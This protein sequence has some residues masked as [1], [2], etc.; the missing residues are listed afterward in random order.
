VGLEDVLEARRLVVVP[1]THWDREWYRT[2]EEFRYRLVRL[3]DDVLDLLER[4]DEF[5][6]FT[7]DGQ[8]VVLADY[9]EVRPRVRERLT[10]L[11]R[12]GRLIVGPWF[13]LPDEW[14]VSGEA[15]IRN[16]RLGMRQAEAFG[17]AMRLGYVPDQFGH[18]GQ[19]PQLFAGFG[20]PAAVLWRGV[21]EDVDRTLFHWEAP[22]GTRL[23][24]VYLPFGYGNAVHLPRDPDSL[25]ARLR[26]EVG[27]LEAMSDVPT[28][29]LMNGSDH[30]RPR[31]DLPR[32]LEH[33]VR[34]IGKPE[35][36][37][38]T[39]PGFVER[40]Q[41][42]APADLPLHRGELRSG[43]RSP[44][45]PGCASARLWIKQ[46]DFRNDRLLTRYLEPLA[47]WVG[48]LGVD[49]DPEVIDHA[50]RSALENHPHDSICGCSVDR[51]H[52][53]M[54]ERFRRTEEI[55]ASHLDLVTA[56]W[57]SR[58]AACVDGEEGETLVVWSPHPAGPAE[59]V[60]DVELDLPVGPKG[61]KAFHLQTPDGRSVAASAE[62]L[63][64]EQVLSELSL[65]PAIVDWMLPALEGEFGGLHAQAV[66]WRRRGEK[67][68]FEVRVGSAPGTLDLVTLRRD[69]AAALEDDGVRRVAFRARRPAR[70]RLR[71]VDE[72]PGWG[73]R[74]YRVVPGAASLPATLE[75]RELSGGGV[76]IAN[77]SW[78]VEVQPDGR[79]MLE[80]RS[81][82]ERIDD[83]LRV[84][85]EGDRGDEYNFDPVPDETPVARPERVRL[86]LDEPSAT[87]VGLLIDA[88]YRVPAG[89]ARHRRARSRRRVTLP[90]RVHLR[91]PRSLDRVDVDI[92]VDNTVQDHRLRVELRAPFKATRFQV[93]SAFEVVERPIAPA[94]SA[95]GSDHPAERPIGACPQRSFACL[96]DGRRTWTVANRGLAEVEALEEGRST[97]LAI[98]LLR[99]VGW[100]SRGDLALRP[101]DAGPP[102]PTPGAQVPGPHRAELSL[103]LDEMGAAAPSAHA[104]RFAYPPLAV[105]GGGGS[106]APVRDGDSLV[107][108]SAPLVL[109]TAIEPRAGGAAVLRGYN[110]SSEPR[111]V[112]VRWLADPGRRLEPIDLAETHSR[113]PLADEEVELELRPWELFTLRVREKSPR[114]EQE[115]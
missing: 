33:A 56:E 61:V 10:K 26:F 4:D 79:V 88:R 7:L 89:L 28:V 84:V 9:L 39:L 93:E 81:G 41:A 49:A 6:H 98:T 47:A 110:A 85:S 54:R 77:E 58:V 23:F 67:L 68:E 75:A 17:G 8:T 76:A 18:V 113:G 78:R 15:L 62:L 105:V 3:L 25:V 100:L 83:A 87:H 13:V 94:P 48:A 34:E 14:L 114:G 69:L 43:L 70:L 103:R 111:R 30:V 38:G 107:A 102:L 2:H 65:P 11:I 42:E 80:S 44:L 36:E 60:A 52:D 1:H 64:P 72:M 63:E 37:I 31:A 95:F 104:H 29:L 73:L 82:G 35:L 21:G 51:V 55:A 112:R 99:A 115:R 74:A 91:L 53:Q 96:D 50:W 24:S 59:A 92:E 109:L 22:D 19:L 5:R 106:A 57:T 32:A 46:A 40:A 27:R 66:R 45:L 12:A 71:F 86:R 20:F 90:V 101:G 108:V 16:L 97:S